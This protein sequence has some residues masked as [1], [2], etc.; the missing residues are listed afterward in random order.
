MPMGDRELRIVSDLNTT[1][2][3]AE[4]LADI[5]RLGIELAEGKPITVCDYDADEAG[6]PTWLVAEGI[7]H[8]D[9]ERKAWQIA[10][11][12]ENVHW[13]PRET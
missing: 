10:Y 4:A 3:S 13:E 2:L 9:A 6:K 11:A 7:A 5:E 1:Y 8:F 12:T